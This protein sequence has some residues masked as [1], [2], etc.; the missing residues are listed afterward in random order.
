MI[1]KLEEGAYSESMSK[2]IDASKNG[3]FAELLGECLTKARPV[4]F[5][6]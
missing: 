2:V 6:M 5:Q 1:R 3:E 4:S